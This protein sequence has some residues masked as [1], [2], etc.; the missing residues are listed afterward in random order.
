M[1]DDTN[2]I[3]TDDQDQEETNQTS[4][5]DNNST[6]V[7]STSPAVSDEESVAGGAP[8]PESDDDVDEIGEEFGIEY[9]QDEPLDLERKVRLTTQPEPPEEDNPTA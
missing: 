5:S 3:P 1:S 8:D 9:A 2:P 6:P 4:R 7:S